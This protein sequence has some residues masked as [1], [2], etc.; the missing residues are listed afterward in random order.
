[1]EWVNRFYE[2]EKEKRAIQYILVGQELSVFLET[3][4]QQPTSF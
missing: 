4:Q 3:I 1:M 2:V